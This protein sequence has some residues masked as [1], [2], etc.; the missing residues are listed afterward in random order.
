M[1]ILVRLPNWL[2]DMVMS[3]GFL[4]QL[5]YFFPD[6]EV[7]VIAKKGIQDLLTFFPPL[8]HQFIFNKDQYKGISGAIRFGKEIRQTEK[9]NL[10]FSLPNSFSSA[11]IGYAAG[12]NKRIGYKKELR[13]IMLSDAYD[14]PEGIHR[15]EEYIRLLELYTGKKA[16]KPDVT[17][18]HQF[19]KKDYVVVNINSEANSRRLTVNKAVELLNGIRRDIEQE[20]IL[21]GAPKEKPFV[22]EVL[23]QL[24][25][26]SGIMNKAGETSLVQLAELLASARLMLST[27]SGPA[28]LAD[29]LHTFTVVLFGA[30]NENH[31]A[32][33]NKE[34][35]QVIRLGEL[36]CEPCENNECVRYGIPQ[37]LERLNTS[38]IVQTIKQH[39]IK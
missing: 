16:Q 19:S 34:F 25:N 18:K 12:T 23:N 36:S 24:E 22:T 7:S 11:L 6:A 29:A 39:L 4:H 2:G 14:I 20:I 35:R 33:Y 15:V 37:C 21:I 26:K 8:K 38:M 9:F 10:F 27:D 3:V 32:P 30:G 1:K 28:H 13:Q 5:P 17:L 31:T